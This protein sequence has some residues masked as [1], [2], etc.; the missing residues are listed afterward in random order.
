MPYEQ[1]NTIIIG[2]LEAK[3]KPTII[4]AN[5]I[6]LPEA[7]PELVKNSTQITK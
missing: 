1:I 6:D 3:R 7:K 5:K 2:T 4:V